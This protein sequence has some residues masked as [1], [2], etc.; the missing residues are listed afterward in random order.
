MKSAH[1][2]VVPQAAP[3]EAEGYRRPHKVVYEKQCWGFCASRAHPEML[4]MRDALLDEL[5][6]R[7][8]PTVRKDGLL[9]ACELAIARQGPTAWCVV[10]N[11]LLPLLDM[12]VLQPRRTFY[13]TKFSTSAALT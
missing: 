8:C 13:S 10:Q 11:V 1:R 12:G 9:L 7:C 4:Q 6:H 2:V 3:M 5:A